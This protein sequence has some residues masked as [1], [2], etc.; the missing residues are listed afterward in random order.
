MLIL[1]AIGLILLGFGIGYAKLEYHCPIYPTYWAV[2]IGVGVTIVGQVAMVVTIYL[3]DYG[4]VGLIAGIIVPFLL[5]GGPM[6]IFQERKE[7]G[8]EAEGND[9]CDG[10]EDDD[11]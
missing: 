10:L 9:C 3:L 2:I 8:F 4:A 11:A 6:A 7:R 5:T 1:I